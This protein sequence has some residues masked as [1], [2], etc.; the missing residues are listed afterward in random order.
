MKKGLIILLVIGLAVCLLVGCNVTTP[1]GNGNAEG[2]SEGETVD[3]VVLV[4]FFT[5]G[6]PNCII[7]EP[8]I[9]GLAEEYDRAKMILVE[10]RPWGTPITPG[11]ND[12]YEWYLPNAG[13]RST[14]T[15]FYNGSNQIVYHGSAY[16][17]FKGPIVNELAKDSEISITVTR[18]ENNGTTT[19]T[20]KIKNISNSAL[21]NLVINGMTFRD[22][23]ESGQR[24][25]V[26]DIFKGVEEVGESL[27]AGAEQSFTF[28][29]EDIQ[30]E[31][32][33]LHGV[34]FVQS[35]STKEV[36]QALYV[37]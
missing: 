17:I 16:Y 12:R 25:L 37:D 13:D 3:R 6:C 24:Y 22:Y 35:S 10:E 7:A 26:K 34:I 23:F 31:I 28:T 1:G 21:D 36:F 27:E 14:P 32:N 4:E 11:A 9:E 5:V 30:W 20:G 18:S 8:I 33:Q 2:G 15:T 19:L 29:L